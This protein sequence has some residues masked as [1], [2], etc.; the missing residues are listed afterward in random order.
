MKT[1]IKTKK[2]IHN[3]CNTHIFTLPASSDSYIERFKIVISTQH[4]S[5]HLGS[6]FIWFDAEWC[7]IFDIQCN[8]TTID[9]VENQLIQAATI[10]AGDCL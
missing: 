7:W 2:S 6:L 1:V 3:A 4:K 5:N 10:F 8:N 9:D